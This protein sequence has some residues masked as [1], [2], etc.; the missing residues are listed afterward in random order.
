MKTFSKIVLIFVAFFAFNTVTAQNQILTFEQL[1]QKAQTF[2]KKHFA[3]KQITT[4]YEQ[5]EFLQSKEYNVIFSDGVEIEFYS[6]GD[7]EEVNCK[8]SPVPTEII[9][10]SISQYVQRNFP[11]VFVKEI[12]KRRNGYDVEISNGL[13]LEFNKQGKFVRIDD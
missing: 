9:P 4:V 6:N 12:K 1:P 5:T 7:W 8:N 10:Q 3:D 2:I 13:D 11:N